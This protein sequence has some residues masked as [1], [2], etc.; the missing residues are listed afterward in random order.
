MKPLGNDII[1]LLSSAKHTALIVA[2][3][4]RSEALSRLLDSI[5]D[6]V[7][8]TVV[9]RWRV[10]D[11]LSGASDLAVYDIIKSKGAKLY[12]RHDLHA[13]YF[14]A[15]DT[16][17]IGSAN[18]TLTALGWRNPANL[19]LLTCVSR[20][21]DYIIEFENI[22]FSDAIHANVEQRDC[23]EAIL[24]QLRKKNI[25]IPD[26]KDTKWHPLPLNWVPQVRNP[27]ELYSVYKKKADIG[28]TLIK[29]MQNELDQIGIIPGLNQ[30]EFRAWIASK[31]IQAPLVVWVIE[32]LDQYG[33]VTEDAL[34]DLLK[35]M[36]DDENRAEAK[37]VLEVL[38][39]WLTYF[40]QIHYETV[41]DG[42]KLRRA[43]KI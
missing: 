3:F 31:I 13:K 5:P 29:Y 36:S 21:L 14:A 25:S 24:L 16:C 42:I 8:I 17:L 41:Q 7:Q 37:E 38:Q 40:L 26:L 28:L 12:I 20:S 18:V 11:L 15:D 19:E 9:T 27:E 32:H 22:L 2:P 30:K 33:D 34:N 39:R 35:Q 4:M 43:K 10:A 1:S 23:L 6:G